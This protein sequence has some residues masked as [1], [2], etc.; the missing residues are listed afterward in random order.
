MHHDDVGRIAAIEQASPSPWSASLIVAELNRP[1]GL[2]L[3]AVGDEDGSVLGWCCGI[4]AAEAEILKIAIDPSQR[5]CGLGTAL[6]LR[7]EALCRDRGCE[8]LLLEVR[9][10]S[11]RAIS[12]YENLGYRSIGCRKKYYSNPQDDALILR[13]SLL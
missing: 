11:N 10:A 4:A 9:A 5:R 1:Q 6:L 3:V 8:A 13:K 12:L 2:Q 7:F